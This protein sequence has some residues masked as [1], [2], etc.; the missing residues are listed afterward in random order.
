[1]KIISGKEI[2]D[3]IKAR[4]K[5]SNIRAE[6][7]PCLAVIDVGEN[8][9]NTLYIGLKKKAVDEIGGTTRVININGDA[10][11]EEVLEKIKDL[12][13][14]VEVH[15]ILLQLPIPE[16]LEPYREDFLEAIAP[17]KDV[18]GFCPRNRGLLMGADPD[19][20]SCAALACMDISRRFMSPLTGKKIL[21]VGDSFDVIQPLALMFIKEACNVSVIPEYHF[22]DIEDID[23]AIVEKGS[24]MVVKQ[25]GIKKGALLIDAG[26][27]WHQER[28]CGNVDRDAVS[29]VDGYLLPVPGGMG[30]L[31]IAE[32][33][34]N[35]TKAAH[36]G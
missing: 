9:E 3:E 18:D 15:G 33:M 22:E 11:R 26:F 19:F 5:E 1:M 36:K 6:I 23:I 20:I 10:S 12:N 34:E 21:L 8:K 25:E 16:S 27:H 28:V 30:P 31:L 29:G 2:A 17:N 32:L 35:L 13:R 14:D 24:P 4:L 7:S